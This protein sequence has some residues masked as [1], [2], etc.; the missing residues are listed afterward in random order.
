MLHLTTL[1]EY[2][3]HINIPPPREMGFDIRQFGETMQTVTLNQ[4]PFR[5]EF[6]AIALK[7]TGA[8]RQVNGLPIRANLF[9]NTPYQVISWDIESDWQGWYIMFTDDFVRANPV[10]NN[11]ITDFPFLTLDKSIPFNLPQTETAFIEQV[12]QKIGIEYESD[13]SDRLAFIRAYTQLLL[14]SVRRCYDAVADTLP[15]KSRENR[16]ADQQVVAQMQQL[17]SQ[18]L[19]NEQI[20]ELARSPS[21]YAEQLNLHPNHLNAIVKRISGK[22][23]SQLVQEGVISAAKSLLNATAL[24]VKE[25]AYQLHF[26][27]PTHFVGYFKKATGQTPHQFREAGRR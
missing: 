23:A 12:F 1:H 21:F 24:T 7:L 11:F 4:P 26:S 9:F 10:W 5:H 25:V 19:I 16:R 14:L 3:H 18:C 8:N 2:C 20:G 27:E 15:L 17:I 22:T 6:Y 13:H